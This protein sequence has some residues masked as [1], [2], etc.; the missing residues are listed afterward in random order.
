MPTKEAQ[1]RDRF[2]RFVQKIEKQNELFEKATPQERIVMCSKDALTMLQLGR[3]APYKGIYVSVDS[4][5]EFGEGEFSSFLKMPDYPTCA[6]CAI[7]GAMVCSVLRRNRVRVPHGEDVDLTYIGCTYVDHRPMEQ[8]QI[9]MSARAREI[10]GNELLRK[11]EAAFEDGAFDYHRVR[12][13]VSTRFAAIYKNLIKN[14]GEKFTYYNSR[15]LVL[16][17]E[18]FGIPH[19]YTSIG[20]DA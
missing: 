9:E 5:K 15:E 11:M 4:D 17:L 1:N 7:G 14:K 18:G 10:Y 3:I 6:V 16:E 8:A 2:A 19:W 20:E 12:G 13:S